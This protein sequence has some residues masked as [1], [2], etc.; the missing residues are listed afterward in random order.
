MTPRRFTPRSR[1]FCSNISQ[2]LNAFVSQGKAAGQADN[3]R[4][5][6]PIDRSRPS[7]YATRKDA[8]MTFGQGIQK[9]CHRLR[10]LM[11]SDTQLKRRNR[12]SSWL[13]ADTKFSQTDLIW[14]AP[15]SSRFTTRRPSMLRLGS[16]LQASNRSRRRSRR[17]QRP[18]ADGGLLSVLGGAA[19]WRLA[20]QPG[21]DSDVRAPGP[22][23][24]GRQISTFRKKTPAGTLAMQEQPMPE[25][26]DAQM[27]SAIWIGHP[28]AAGSSSLE[29]PL[30]LDQ[31]LAD[32]LKSGG[33]AI[34]SSLSALEDPDRRCCSSS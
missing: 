27:K 8:W 32:H 30:P 34:G 22:A 33:S 7:R 2:V 9:C 31:M 17:S 16:A 20:T 1:S 11:N 4:G 29:Q 12:S 6:C 14:Q 13:T 15:P 21:A 24:E 26:T 5:L 25:P 18:E 3:I 23:S 28:A 10:N 19:A